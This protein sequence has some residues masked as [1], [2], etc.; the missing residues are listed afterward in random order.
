MSGSVKNIKQYTFAIYIGAM[1]LCM[2]INLTGSVLN[3]IMND[4]RITLSNGGLMTFFQFIGG[5]AAIIILSKIA[6]RLKKPIILM[7]A[8]A[9]ASVM[10]FFIGGFPTFALFM[11]FYLIFGASLGIIDAMN[12]AVLTDLYSH[13]MDPM[14]SILHAMSG[15]G[16][17]IIPLVSAAIGTANWK[18]IFQS[19]AVIVCLIFVFQLVMYLIN[20]KGVDYF[21]TSSVHKAESKS[22]AREFY[23]DKNIRLAAASTL[24][25]G[26]SQGAVVTWVV[27][28][29]HEVFPEAG[30]FGWALGLSFYWLGSAI[31]RISMAIIPALKRID[32]KKL[33]V[34]G[35]VLSGIVLLIGVISGNYYV[36]IICVLLYGILNGASLP[37]TVGLMSS[38]YPKNTGLASSLSYIALY[39]GFAAAAV[40]MGVVAAAFGMNVMMS[41]PAIMII[42]SGLIAVPI[43]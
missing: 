6:D 16:A 37:R 29:G 9:V 41:M 40:A 17:T 39:V 1:I 38:R 27:K 3:N 30:E 24:F 34:V 32:S 8:F 33:I 5:V 35:G 2:C 25:F 22:G 18:N 4:Y 12:N 10:L 43:K 11:I 19:V 36:F 20:K 31:C 28:Y 14:L 21:Y 15:I 23:A 13:N 42:I 26:L 7:T